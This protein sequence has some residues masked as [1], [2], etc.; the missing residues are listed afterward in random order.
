MF[1][2]SSTLVS[3]LLLFAIVARAA[4]AD[5]ASTFPRPNEWCLLK[6]CAQPPANIVDRAVTLDQQL[7]GPGPAKCGDGICD[8][9]R[10]ETCSSCAADCGG[11]CKNGPPATKCR[12][13]NHFALTFDDGASEFTHGLVELLNKEGVKATFFVNGVWLMRDKSN[14]AATKFAYDSGHLIQSHTYTHR[15][16]GDT[17]VP[18]SHV[19]T[20]LVFNDLVI[21]SVIGRRPRIVRPPYLETNPQSLT[22]METAG[23]V[24]ANINVD[25]NDWRLAESGKDMT[26]ANVA[27]NVRQA[28]A[29]KRGDGSW[30]HLQHDRYGFS[31]QAVGEIIGFLRGE[32]VQFVTMDVCLGIDGYRAANDNPV[33]ATAIAGKTLLG[34]GLPSVNA[35]TTSTTTTT[36]ASAT[37]TGLPLIPT[38]APPPSNAK[39]GEGDK[40]SAATVGRVP[41]GVSMIAAV[42]AAVAGVLLY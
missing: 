7:F 4:P 35:S 5:I 1:P 19:R 21:E 10:G 28:F 17:K 27:R 12:Q 26:S 8:I 38:Q 6:D 11:P 29:A 33:L 42:A 23:Y 14:A 32:G 41:G 40:P 30:I 13:R 31:T 22:F 39:A 20:E 24:A 36:T 18:Y 2:Y 25:S 37:S 3:S 15:S 9:A 16:L 34:G